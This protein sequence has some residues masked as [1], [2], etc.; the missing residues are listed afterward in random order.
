MLY[1]ANDYMQGAYQEIL[2]V[3]VRTNFEN[4]AGYGTDRYCTAL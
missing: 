2:D 3:V 4:L 1:F